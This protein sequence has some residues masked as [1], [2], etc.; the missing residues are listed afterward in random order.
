MRRMTSDDGFTLVEVLITIVLIGVLFSISV[1]IIANQTGAA[2]ER[3]AQSDAALIGN[4]VITALNGYMSFG[5]V[6][7]AIYL[8]DGTNKLAFQQMT[9]ATPEAWATGPGVTSYVEKISNGSTLNNES[10]FAA[11]LGLQWCVAVTNHGKVGVFTNA[12]LDRNAIGC[13]NLAGTPKYN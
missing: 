7:G 1:P 10:S 11:G 9:G 6:S 5:S 12:G 4:D 13:N 8:E 2:Y 3:A